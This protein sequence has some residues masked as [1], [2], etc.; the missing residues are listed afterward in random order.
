MPGQ[1]RYQ[2]PARLRGILPLLV[3]VPIWL[4]RLRLGWLLGERFLV[5]HHRGRRSGR[6]YRTALEVVR[7]DPET[8]AYHVI[9]AWG[10]QADWFQ[11]V[12]ANPDVMTEVGTR[13]L[14]ARAVVLSDVEGGRVLAAYARRH[15]IAW[16]GLARL[17]GFP[18]STA[19][20]DLREMAQTMPVV[21]L[22]PNDSV[23]R[24][25]G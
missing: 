4:Y 18:T 7:R 19:E 17:L 1:D 25:T 21:M 23:D 9:S 14:P 8:G 6:P 5:L 11:N 20:A 3:R 15:P 16:R 13:R 22:L 24:E 12:E 10:R 2:P